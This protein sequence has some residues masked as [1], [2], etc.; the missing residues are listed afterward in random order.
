MVAKDFFLNNDT[1]ILC[2]R[3][4]SLAGHNL[5]LQNLFLPPVIKENYLVIA[6]LI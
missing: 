2:T 6:F 5:T 4:S 1:L 3:M